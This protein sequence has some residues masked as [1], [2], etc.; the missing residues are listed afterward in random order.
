MATLATGAITSANTG[1]FAQQYSSKL[2]VESVVDNPINKI[3]MEDGVIN[4][5]NRLKQEAGGTV[6]LY[7]ALRLDTFGLTGDIDVYSNAILAEKSN[8]TLNV[9]KNTLP[10][11][12]PLQ[13]TQTQQFTSFEIGSANEQIMTDWASSLVTASMLNQ[14]GGNTATSISQFACASTAFT[15]GDLIR[16]TGN[17]SAIIPT[18]HFVGSSATAVTTDASVNSGNKLSITDFQR[19]SETIMSQISGRP[20]WQMLTNGAYQAIA[21]ISQTGLNQLI[22]DPVTAAQ[23]I[24]LSQLLNANIAGGNNMKLQNFII[25]GLPFKFVVV[26]DSWLP[27]GVNLGTGAEVAATRRAIIVGRNALDMSFGKGFS[28]AGK[29]PIPGASVEMDTTYKKLNKQGYGAAT[30]LWGCKKAQSTGSGDG[31]ST[32]YDLSTYVICHFSNI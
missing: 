11:T 20:T 13:G 30:L 28:P 27:R 4:L 32:S 23:G 7:N 24:Q 22:N 5:E 18:Y 21:I 19:A 15:G 6:T 16:I 10:L 29:S 17:N 12:W 14:I 9:L 1:F 26:P 3:F 2:Y 31:N 8:R 25:P